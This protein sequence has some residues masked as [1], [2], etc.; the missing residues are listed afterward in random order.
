[1]ENGWAVDDGMIGSGWDRERKRSDNTMPCA[2]GKKWK[3]EFHR[4]ILNHV[5][6]CWIAI[7]QSSS[8]ES[9]TSG[10]LIT[11][12]SAACLREEEC[13]TWRSL[14]SFDTSKD[15]GV[16]PEEGHEDD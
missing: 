4:L 3:S 13:W 11:G 2:R 10:N 12:A 8:C 14:G 1:M 16:S 7:T 9:T 5:A 6:F 15:V